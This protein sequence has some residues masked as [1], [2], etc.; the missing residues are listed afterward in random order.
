MTNVNNFTL[1]ITP[2]P[3][4][5]MVN[6]DKS[7]TVSYPAIVQNTGILIPFYIYPTNAELDKLLAPFANIKNVPLLVVLNPNSG[8]G[9]A[10]DVNYANAVTRIKAAG[11]IPFGYISTSYNNRPATQ[12]QDE[13]N[14]YISW[15]NV[16]GIFFDEEGSNANYYTQLTAYAKQKGIQQTIANPGTFVPPQTYS[17]A[18]DITIINEDSKYPGLTTI[19][20]W[21]SYARSKSALLVYNQT[22]LTDFLTLINYIKT[23]GWIYIT[24]DNLPNPWDTL[25]TYWTTLVQTLSAIN[26]LRQG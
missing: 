17:S 7:I 24:N 23:V 12:V 15:Y 20:P 2:Q 3:S 16:S 25:P 5:I 8:V 6:A 18:A 19:A 1:N 9:T 4:T 22:A 14:K 11:A 13:I 10:K 26:S 21:A